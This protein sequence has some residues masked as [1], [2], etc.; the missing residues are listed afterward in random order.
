MAQS[1]KHIFDFAQPENTKEVEKLKVNRPPPL[2][3]SLP[4]TQSA[5]LAV[6]QI[7]IREPSDCCST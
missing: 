2:S 6:D 3:R 5:V 4:R 1:N 7:F